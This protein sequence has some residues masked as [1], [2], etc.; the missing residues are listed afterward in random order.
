[1]YQRGF[2]YEQ[3]DKY[4]IQD[5]YNM[6]NAIVLKIL[7]YPE[8]LNSQMDEIISARDIV[9]KQVYGPRIDQWWAWADLGILSLLSGNLIEATQAYERF[10]EAGARVQDCNSTLDVLR[11]LSQALRT[12]HNS[13]ADSI[14]Q[15]IGRLERSKSC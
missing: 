4:G 14:N 10:W 6:A 13:V 5:S 7:M 11:D 2:F 15:I 3:N 1:M 12:S 8:T 9:Q